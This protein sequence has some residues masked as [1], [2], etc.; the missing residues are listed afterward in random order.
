MCMG[1]WDFYPVPIF[2]PVT[3]EPVAM[4]PITVTLR[5]VNHAGISVRYPQIHFEYPRGDLDRCW[6]SIFVFACTK[7]SGALKTALSI[8]SSNVIKIRQ[9]PRLSGVDETKAAHN[10]FKYVPVM[11]RSEEHTSELQS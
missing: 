6:R 8:G 7:L 11:G 2:F 10:C 9:F 5:R 1:S 4:L 3:G